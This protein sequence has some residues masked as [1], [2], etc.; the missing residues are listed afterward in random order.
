MTTHRFKA[1]ILGRLLVLGALALALTV[2]CDSN[3]AANTPDSGMSPDA[4]TQADAATNP[5]AGGQ[6]DAGPGMDGGGDPDA[7]VGPDGGTGPDAGPGPDAGSGDLTVTWVTGDLWANCMPMVPPDPWHASYDLLYDN[8]AGTSP[9]SATV[10][11]TRLVF[12]VATNP[13]LNLTVA[14]TAVGP[15]AAGTSTTVTHTKT[16]STNDLP[17]DCGYCGTPAVFEIT[18]DVG[19]QQRLITSPPL[20]P[21]CAY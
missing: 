10:V 15:V 3:K 12:Q 11:S 16:G 1:R 13:T 21:M 14:P 4:S 17:N 20:N 5:D 8:T 7:T 18:V 9:A 19:G 2:G 6:G